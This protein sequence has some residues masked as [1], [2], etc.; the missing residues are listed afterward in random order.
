MGKEPEMKTKAIPVMLRE[1]D[2]GE[3]TQATKEA[4]KHEELKVEEK[5]KGL[6]KSCKEGVISH[7]QMEAEIEEVKERLRQLLIDHDILT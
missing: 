6:R 4:L 3:I 7:D 1:L 5:I 2:T